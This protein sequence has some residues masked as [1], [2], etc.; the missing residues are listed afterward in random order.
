VLLNARQ[1]LLQVLVPPDHETPDPVAELFTRT[2]RQLA[3]ELR[4]VDADLPLSTTLNYLSFITAG[5]VLTAIQ[6]I[7]RQ[8]GF[9]LGP[10]ALR[11]MVRMLLP[12]ENGDPLHYDVAVDRP[13]RTLFG[14]GDP[15]PLSGEF[16]AVH[17]LR[18]RPGAGARLA[19]LL[20]LPALAIPGNDY[21]SLLQRLNGWVP[22]NAVLNEY[23]TT[24]QQLLEQVIQI[25][26]NEKKLDTGLNGLFRNLV[27]STAWQESC[28]RQF[29]EEQGQIRPIGSHAGAI[30]IMQVNQ[31]VWRGFYD[32]DSL[33]QDVGYNARA[34]SEILHHYLVDYAIAKGEHT[35]NG[36]EDNLAHATYAMYN[37]GP[38]QMK[39]YREAKTPKSLR[40]IDESFWKKYQTVSAGNVLGVAECYTN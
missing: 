12:D 26:L 8:T 33:K 24:V 22:N 37:G 18:L 21:Q 35:L 2:W 27:L 25:N 23:L 6:E 15:I 16:T 20:L 9:E 36:G 38:R 14:F 31:H 39:R 13:L 28:W 32:V 3:P 30:G 34:G 19:G 5:D 17:P 1:D 40:R 4:R 10:D 11:H 7:G 29:V